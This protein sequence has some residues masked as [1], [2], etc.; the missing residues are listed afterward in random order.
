LGFD[1]VKT[2]RLITKKNKTGVFVLK[3]R[4]NRRKKNKSTVFVLFH[5]RKSVTRELGDGRGLQIR[6]RQPPNDTLRRGLP[7]KASEEG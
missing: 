7:A 5:G 6:C 2:D 4:S 3:S 1:K